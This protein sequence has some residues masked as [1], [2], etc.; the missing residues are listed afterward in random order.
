MAYILAAGAGGLNGTGG[1][2][3][4][5]TES[6]I[7][8]GSHPGTK[9]FNGTISDHLDCWFGSSTS[10][11]EW[12]KFQFP[13]A[14][15]IGK[16]RIWPRYHSSGGD[17]IRAPKSWT[18]DGSNDDSNWTTLDS[19]SNITSW[20]L[21][22]TTSVANETEMKEYTISSPGSYVYYRTSISQGNNDGLK[23]F[24]E[25]SLY[26]LVNPP[27]TPSG[28]AGTV[29]ST[30]SVSLSWNA[31]TGDVDSY[32]LEQSPDNSTWTQ[33]GGT[34]T[35]TSYTS[36]GLTE[37]GTYYYRVSATNAGGT[38]SVSSA[39]TVQLPTPPGAPTNLTGSIT[40]NQVV[41]SWTAPSN[42]G[43]TAISGYKIEYSTDNS[44]WSI[45]EANTG[46]AAVSYTT[47]VTYQGTYYY[48][49]SGINDSGAGSASVTYSALITGIPP[50]PP[51]GI[52]AGFSYVSAYPDTSNIHGL[53]KAVDYD[54]S[55][56]VWTDSSGFGNHANCGT[57]KATLETDELNSNLKYVQ[58][59]TSPHVYMSFPNG[60]LY[61]N[62][63]TS[64]YT[65]IHAARRGKTPL[66]S[67][68]DNY[69]RIFQDQTL[70]F[71]SGTHRDWEGVFY[72]LSAYTTNVNQNYDKNWAISGDRAQ[73]SWS[74]SYVG[75]TRTPAASGY[76]VATGG[77]AGALNELRINTG[78]AP[79]DQRCDSQVNE[80]VIWKVQLSDADILTALGA[81]E[82]SVWGSDGSGGNGLTSVPGGYV[83]SWTAGHSTVTGYKV[84]YSADKTNWVVDIADT[85][86][87]AT[88]HTLIYQVPSGSTIHFRVST[89][90]LRGTSVSEVFSIWSDDVKPT[91]LT[92][93]RDEANATLSWSAPAE[94]TP[95]SYR[96]E[97]SYD[98][99]NWNI[100]K[101]STGNANT[102]YS[103]V[104]VE[105]GTT[106]FRV[107]PIY[108]P[109]MYS[110][111]ATLVVGGRPG[112]PDLTNIHG[113]YEPEDYD[114]STG[115][116]DDS[117]GFGNHAQC[118]PNKATLHTDELNSN[119]KYVQFHASPHIYMTFPD[120][121]LYIGGQANKYTFIHAARRGRTPLSDSYD[122]VGRIFQDQSRN[123]LSGYWNDD[124]G[125][126]YHEGV[127]GWTDRGTEKNW[128]I[129]ADQ[130]QKTWF[131]S[132]ISGTR[133]PATG[134]Y[135][136]T[137]GNGSN[138]YAKLRI[139]TG[140]SGGEICDCQVHKMVM[141]KVKLSDADVL[142][143]I[144]VLEESVWGEDGT[145]GLGSLSSPSPAKI[146]GVSAT[147]EVGQSVIT[148]NSD[149][150]STSY[151]VIYGTNNTSWTVASA[152]VSGTTI[153][154]TGLVELTQ[155]YYRVC[156]IDALGAGEFS[157][158]V[159]ATTLIVPIPPGPPTGITLDSSSANQITVSWNAPA[160]V[161]TGAISGYKVEVSYSDGES[162]T[163][164]SLNTN[165]TATSYVLQE[166]VGGGDYIF[167][168]S[169]ISIH[170]GTG[171]PSTSTVFVSIPL[172]D[173]HTMVSR[174][175]SVPGTRRLDRVTNLILPSNSSCY[176]L[177]GDLSVGELAAAPSSPASGQ[178][179]VL[180]TLS[181]GRVSYKSD[182]F[183]G[184]LS[185]QP[186]TSSVDGLGFS[187]KLGIGITPVETLTVNGN[188]SI[189]GTLDTSGPSLPSGTGT[190]G[191]FISTNGSG[192]M[193]W[194]TVTVTDPV[195]SPTK[196]SIYNGNLYNGTQDANDTLRYYCW[197]T[198]V[199]TSDIKYTAGAV[200]GTNSL[201]HIKA[202]G[203]YLI[204][205]NLYVSDGN[206]NERSVMW[207][208]VALY[209][210]EN[211]NTTRGTLDYEYFMDSMY[212]R[213]DQTPYDK[214]YMGGSLRICITSAMVAAGCQIEITSRLLYSSTP[215][216]TNNC[217][218][219][220][221]KLHIEKIA[222]TY[223]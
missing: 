203:D 113:W 122:S 54:P 2:Q 125:V 22:T 129:C 56:G 80:I 94:G 207:L 20:A 26:S 215:G 135:I 139:N 153:T 202:P 174:A 34:L 84:E 170:A 44:S 27:A 132:Y 154:I 16:Y 145:G 102:T 191:Q 205:P 110:N 183:S 69:G 58:F 76:N 142:L 218:Q 176:Y 107:V 24:G 196:T 147:T 168:I 219:N 38:S 73:K 93:V 30:T 120:N 114:P 157:D 52:S 220:S 3:G 198:S 37:G 185:E 111:T 136:N 71:V 192:T 173:T 55:T 159:T 96:I 124:E 186:F 97:Y 74:S 160:V 116:W 209:T 8:N 39:V 211:N 197:N 193:Q 109:T 156:G 85:G 179:G 48:R 99:T 177:K 118:G 204:A 5:V 144:Q 161:G 150:I 15:T 112:L 23:G 4:T 194:S 127:V 166:K 148:W 83:I 119:L 70:N 172:A 92:A 103:F 72:Q 33:I 175:G 210:G 217:N 182:S 78:W 128:G 87:T 206:V 41:L 169:G 81:L 151:K 68:Y 131:S 146:T 40:T 126:F 188:A 49:V 101:A 133:T 189:S 208:V 213:D 18:I 171:N 162:W 79:T 59:T 67:A 19:Q 89:I 82:T 64:S 46:S 7:V 141:W 63:T 11:T 140:A 61:P 35:T 9:G 152:T 149:S 199:D 165:S 106:Y 117:S 100:E 29:S 163:V 36:T 200:Q 42:S 88:S 115:I 180:Y 212:N 86:S 28:L 57:N 105:E 181:D 31:P 10:A 17:K 138:S 143:A 108:V 178:G 66:S 222:Y 14:K 62:S 137:G 43:S 121:M 95:A 1:A 221:S 223:T 65:L 104:G 77:A 90:G 60:M 91:S 25:M 187:N 21:T 13:S 167:R 53:Y 12:I 45:L 51:S 130:Q 184:Y 201:M 164:C 50:M 190:S 195:M 98:Q 134:Y 75:G 32:T 123:W 47:T 155:Y 214:S 6:S 216:G 158:S